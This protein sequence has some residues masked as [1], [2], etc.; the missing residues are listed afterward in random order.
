MWKKASLAWGLGE[1]REKEKLETRRQKLEWRK[2]KCSALLIVQ[3]GLDGFIQTARCQVRLDASIERARA[4]VLIEPQPQFLQLFLRQRSNR[5]LEFFHF[6]PFMSCT[7]T[8][9]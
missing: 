3:R 1:G 7:R 2:Q 8:Q 6:L 5:A 9:F 4:C